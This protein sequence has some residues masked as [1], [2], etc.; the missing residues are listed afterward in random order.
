MG[1]N[2]EKRIC[3]VITSVIQPCDALLMNS[4]NRTIYSVEERIQQT[5]K[6]INS[7]KRFCPNAK[8]LLCEAGEKNFESVFGN[9]V[10]YYC[11]LGNQERVKKAVSSKFKG[12]GECQMLLESIKLVPECDFI[13]KISGRYYLTDDFDLSSFDFFAFNFLNYLKNGGFAK[14]TKYVKG[15]HSTRL[16]G[17]STRY[18]ARYKV[19]LFFSKFELR[20]GYSIESVLPKYL[21]GCNFLYHNKI[22]VAGNIGVNR[23]YIEE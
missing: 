9:L 6:T 19:A 12:W 4:K 21:K 8:I 7:I 11:Y 2:S 5:K 17:F 18:K 22:G 15:S 14:G 3:F 16:Y 1:K 23:E 13:F 20:L 10:D